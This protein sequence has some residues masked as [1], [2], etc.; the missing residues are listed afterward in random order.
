MQIGTHQLAS[1]IN[2]LFS[3]RK[4]NKT[5]NKSKNK[6]AKHMSKKVLAIV[7][8]VALVLTL[9][10]SIA[11][12]GTTSSNYDSSVMKMNKFGIIL[13]YGD[14][15]LGAGD[16]VTRA[17][18]AVMVVKA[19]GLDDAAQA[20][21]GTKPVFDDVT[22]EW[23]FGYVN[24]A[25]Q[26]G[27]IY[28]IG[29][30]KFAPTD[31]VT[32]VQA[33]AMVERAMGY[34]K[35][36]QKLGGY[37]AGYVALA[38]A[39]VKATKADASTELVSLKLLDGI[40]EPSALPAARGLVCKLIDNALA[41]PFFAISNF[42]GSDF[43][44]TA[45]ETVTFLSKMG[46]SSVNDVVV[47]K[48]PGKGGE[49]G[50][51]SYVTA[52]SA[53]NAS[54]TDVEYIGTENADSFFAMDVNLWKNDDGKVAF[55]E[56]KTA[57]TDVIK[58]SIFEKNSGKAKI[59]GTSYDI[60][61]NVGTY[62]NWTSGNIASA[63]DV[64][65][66]NALKIDANYSDKKVDATV[67]LRDGKV[68]FIYG[69]VYTGKY[70]VTGISNNLVSRIKKINAVGKTINL[71]NGANKADYTITKDGRNFAFTDIAADDLVYFAAKDDVTDTAKINGNKIAI[72]VVRTEVKGNI[73]AAKPNFASPD[74]LTIGSAE[75]NLVAGTSLAGIAFGD[76]VKANLDLEGNIYKIARDT[77]TVNADKYAIVVNTGKSTNAYG[78]DTFYVKLLLTDGTVKEYVSTTD[79]SANKARF[80]KYALDSDGKVSTITATGEA[81]AT[82]AIDKTNNKLGTMPVKS[83][84]VAYNVTNAHTGVGDNA[85]VEAV[86]VPWAQV[87]DNSAGQALLTY[88]KD[89]DF[90]YVTYIVADNLV[91]AASS[92][93]YAI[94]KSDFYQSG[95]NENTITV[96]EGNADKTYRT[97]ALNVYA[98]KEAVVKV[99]VDADGKASAMQ[100]LTAVPDNGSFT[101]I[102]AM[103]AGL[104][105]VKIGATIYNLADDA[106]VY[107]VTG[108]GTVVTDISSLAKDVKVKLYTN[109][110]SKVAVVVID[111]N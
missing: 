10:G 106:A 80:V 45:D 85:D 26:L 52:S 76:A 44:Y 2:P 20:S 24:V 13:G 33:L 23:S 66:E 61:T 111:N 28:G 34:E 97:T 12:A 89:G 75:Y 62:I 60:N 4:S 27:I 68:D 15:N 95:S 63:T 39:K 54:I 50:K 72:K 46:Y 1:Q 18:F 37:P 25:S 43:E 73:N 64:S 84:V 88:V 42:N 87:K 110:D 32:L 51:V 101:A 92:D 94:V 58:L 71:E 105:Q 77:T 69:N 102:D 40:K 82:L 49:A 96:T 8:A 35:Y 81:A 56:K 104:K 59:N 90:S 103:D 86:I 31:K 78:V 29:G 48:T 74:K 70:D 17:Q 98:A 36:A 79:V 108:D 65:V 5:N 38:N 7:V 83:N 53:K 99:T 67:I 47:V 16:D 22:A 3:S 19:L 9:F 55:I 11:F 21:A 6:E 14:G 100:T 30:N 91:G 109:A 57:E 41:K 107:D 93:K